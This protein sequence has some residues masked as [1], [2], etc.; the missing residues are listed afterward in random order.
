[1]PNSPPPTHGRRFV[2]EGLSD[3]MDLRMLGS[4]TEGLCSTETDR[5]RGGFRRKVHKK[6]PRKQGNLGNKVG[7]NPLALKP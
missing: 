6:I 5:V 1:M 3:T 2:N 7:V 4:A